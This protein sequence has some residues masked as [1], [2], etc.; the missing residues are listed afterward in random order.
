MLSIG[1]LAAGP[2]AGRYYV[3]QVALG[4][5]DY[6]A[7][8]GEAPG[9][10]VGSGAASLGLTGEVNE[11]GVE[12]LLSG[13]DPRSGELLGRPLGSGA[14][15]GFD[16]T[17]RA[18]KS[19]GV[20]FGVCEPE[21]VREIVEAH[22][23]AV[24]DALDYLEREACRARRGQGG[25]RV[26]EGRGF[27]AA[28][29]R[30]R[31]SRAGDPLLHTHVVVANATQGPDGRWTA[32]DGRPLYRHAKTA[33][34][35]YQATL[36]AEL[37]D[38][39]GLRW[40]AVER[41]T[42]DVLGVPRRLIEHFSTRRAEIVELMAARGER[43]ARAAQIATLETR[44]R[45]EYGVPVNP[46][47]EEWRARAAEHGLGRWEL[48]RVL[49]RRLEPPR[50][51]DLD[52]LAVWLE[53]EKGLTRQ[54]STFTRRD[55]VQVFAQTARDGAR[56]EVIERQAAAFLARA[57]IIELDPEAG[58]ALYTTRGL[59]RTERELLAG[60]AARSPATVARRDAVDAALAARRTLGDEQRELVVALTA[61]GDAVQA[62]RAAAG[63]GKTFALDAA[64]EAWRR[65]DMPVL[66][67]ALSARAAAELR[68][69]AGVDATTIAR[70]RKALD[71]GVALTAGS[72]LIVDEAGMVGT[73]DLAALAQA[74]ER[75]AAKLVLVGDD[76]QLPEI[77]AG[78]AFRALAE[79]L[80]ALE[81]REVRRQ[82]DGW[83]R[84]ALAALRDGDVER[85]ARE[86]QEH[87]RLVAAPNA[88]AAR[89]ALVEDWWSARDQG[90]VALMLAHRRSDVADLNARARERMR[91]AGR[92]GADDLHAAGRAFAIGDR[93]VAT[94]ND[95]RLEV[96]NGD[97]G[98]IVA[99]GRDGLA[100][101]FDR[102]RRADVPER[103]VREG[104]LDHGYAI[105]A[106][107]AQGATVDCAFVLG[108]DE[109]YREWGYTALSRHRQAARF[110][111]SATPAFLNQAPAPL[112]APSD[113]SRHVAGMLERS[114]AE[115]LA[116]NG[117]RRDLERD[118]LAGE[119]A[120]ARRRLDDVDERLGRLWNEH[121]RTPWYQ[122]S[123]RVRLDDLIAL[124]GRDR[125]RGLEEIER[126]QDALR[127]R[128]VAPAPSVWRRGDPLA[129]FEPTPRLT[130]DRALDRLRGRGN[131]LGARDTRIGLEL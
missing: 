38:R 128:P 73:R 124:G 26:V 33:G 72:V 123:R 74:A 27:V 131:D 91:T 110:Y 8:E 126:L 80:G 114:R 105:T 48:R 121:A 7:G 94:R 60:A 85:F 69:Q 96:A 122:R 115:Q 39:L 20:L 63:T 55:V 47:R 31:S 81:L 68:D 56:A 24:A 32:P 43:S 129:A 12:R 5:E 58:E 79:R 76:R 82:R 17:F 57:E 90:A 19:V 41:G 103:Y 30:H 89:A 109:L 2:G 59:V 127:E 101:D 29:F 44:R 49:R 64:V 104:H 40:Q 98:V 22:D 52:A 1:K 34:Y 14:V 86:Y 18:P 65:S 28:A 102:G 53:S 66:G 25:S 3:D 4:R 36:R 97:A 50:R 118:G 9:A 45:K 100:I 21:V 23:A 120:D 111:V 116:L 95:H 125:D 37:T 93:V 83:D 113:V 11:E 87:G 42:A 117:I 119:L 75:A 112:Q 106:H 67:C 10:W 88:D 78:G 35:L 62:V 77:E 15:A 84:D 108:S 16:L 61:R 71:E 130:R 6:Y 99:I 13:R 92:L 54:R 51:L 46:L 107:R 70:L